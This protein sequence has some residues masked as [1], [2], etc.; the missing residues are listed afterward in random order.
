MAQ[1]FAKFSQIQLDD[2][3]DLE[4]Y[5]K[6]LI[7]DEKIDSDTAENERW[8]ERCVV[9]ASTNRGSVDC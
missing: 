3:V 9:V 7:L 2:S 1:R 8:K 5:R 6:V 4:K